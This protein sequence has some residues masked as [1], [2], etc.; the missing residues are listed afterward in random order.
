METVRSASDDLL[1]AMNRMLGLIAGLIET[2]QKKE[3]LIIADDVEGL[4]ELLAEEAG[5]SGAVK[6]QEKELR[7]RAD[8]L[9]RAAGIQTDTAGLKEICASIGDPVCCGRLTA[10][11]NDI[12]EAVG[13]LGRQ[14]EK[15][16][17]LLRQRIGYADYMLSA[18]HSPRDRF[19]S[20]DMLGNREDGPGDFS[21]LDY[22]A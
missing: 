20:Y 17:E 12:T 4:E 2:A 14:N 7:Y 5:T 13:R 3:A 18:L 22:H 10:A 15:L 11:G 8:G 21:L 16:N 6:R 1:L 9:R 19:N